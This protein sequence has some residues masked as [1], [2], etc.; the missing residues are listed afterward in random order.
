M[1]KWQSQG[2]IL[3]VQGVSPVIYSVCK[4]ASPGKSFVT[5]LFSNMTCSKSNGYQST[6]EISSCAPYN[7]KQV[8]LI[9]AEST[10]DMKNVLETVEEM[11]SKYS[12]LKGKQMRKACC[13]TCERPN[14]LIY[15]ENS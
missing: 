6:W 2:Y 10:P 13:G 3:G 4:T 15:L 7:R 1:G 11:F 5:T 9:P 8:V 14:T 12:I